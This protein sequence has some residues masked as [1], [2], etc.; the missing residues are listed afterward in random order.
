MAIGVER[1]ERRRRY[2]IVVFTEKRCMCSCSSVLRRKDVAAATLCRT[3][4]AVREVLA[5]AFELQNV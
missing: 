2:V 1:L 4:V 3:W 5:N